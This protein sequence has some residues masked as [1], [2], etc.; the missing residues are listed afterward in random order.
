MINKPIFKKSLEMRRSLE[1]NILKFCP[2]G[3][4]EEVGRNCVF[5]EYQDEIIVVDAGIQ[6]P[7]EETP[8]IDF[9]IPNTTYLEPKKRDVKALILTHGHY[10][11]IHA[12][13][14]II[15]KIG[16]PIIYAA[17]LTKA[18][19]EKRFEEFPNLPKL[20]FQIVRNGDKLRLSEYFTAEFFDIGHNIPDGLGFILDTPVGKMVH[21]GDFRVNRDI[22]GNPIGENTFRRLNEMGIHSVF[23]DSTNADIEGASKSEETVIKELE[24]LF[25]KAEGRI[26]VTTF[27]SLLDRLATIIEISEKL[28]RKVAINGRSMK[29]NIQIMKNLGYLKV[30]KGQIVNVEELHGIKDDKIMILTTGGQGEPNAGLTKIANGEHKHIRFKPTDTVIFSSSVV[31]GNERSVQTLQDNIA[32][33][34]NEVYNSK[35]LDIH[36]SG[37]APKEDLKLVLELV[38]PKFVVPANAYY[39]KRKACAKI[40][41]EAGMPAENA[42]LMDNGQFADISKTGFKVTSQSTPTDYVMVDGL[43]VGDVQEVVLRDRRMLAQEGM[44]V[45]IATISREN[46][47]F[48]K[49][50]DIISRGFIY[51]KENKELLDAI[52]TKLKHILGR[53]PRH[54]HPE[55]DYIKTL[56]RDQIGQLL[57]TKTKRRPMVLP[58]IIEV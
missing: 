1:Q 2:L 4:F 42:I 52:R 50:P 9:I 36:A 43:G 51:L 14:Y 24:I 10:D 32:R 15:E 56:V 20:K 29:D 25:K 8:G 54:Q 28:G 49:N 31:P 48:I 19:V 17:P 5:F 34:V 58:V 26:V 33:Q 13:P 22:K 23:L 6:F 30:K 11:H 55:A 37:H 46:G 41:R 3:G 57:Y 38:K 39:F 21:F 27:A 16:N 45:V 35:F 47:R 44:V 53:L 12:L 18:L 7:E 40:A